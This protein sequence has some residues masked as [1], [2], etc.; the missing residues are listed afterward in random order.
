MNSFFEK[1]LKH[2]IRVFI[3]N[4][5]PLELIFNRINL[6]IKE[7]IKRGHI[8]KQEPKSHSV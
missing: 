3:D 1:N 2:V 6:K 7:L 8:K 4:A 5:Y